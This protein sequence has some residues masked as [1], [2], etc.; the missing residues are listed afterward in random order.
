MSDPREIRSDHQ[1]AAD[2]ELIPQHWPAGNYTSEL[3]AAAAAAIAQLGAY[4]EKA[5]EAGALPVD[6]ET[7]STI[8]SNLE[9][10]AGKASDALDGWAPAPHGTGGDHARN[11]VRSAIYALGVAHDDLRDAAEW[12]LEPPNRPDRTHVAEGRS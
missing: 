7:S 12:L 1:G 10:G 5:A 4:L 2:N 11:S 8:L 6:V 3:V 9:K